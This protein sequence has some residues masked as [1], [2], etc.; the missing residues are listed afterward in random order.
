MLALHHE[1][2]HLFPQYWRMEKGFKEPEIES[3]VHKR[4]AD[5]AACMFYADAIYDRPMKTFELNPYAEIIW[6]EVIK[7]FGESSAR[8]MFLNGYYDKVVSHENFVWRLDAWSNWITRTK[9]TSLV[10]P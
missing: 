3:D 10:S 4:F 9:K 5:E 6:G 7:A 2:G 1:V 8:E